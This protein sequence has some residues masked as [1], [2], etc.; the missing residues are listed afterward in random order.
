MSKRIVK[1]GAESRRWIKRFNRNERR[2]IEQQGI[3]GK[4]RRRLEDEHIAGL[5]AAFAEL[6]GS[7]AGIPNEVYIFRGFLVADR[8]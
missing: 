1:P 6:Y 5:H 2:T 3:S 8:S 4:V 7:E